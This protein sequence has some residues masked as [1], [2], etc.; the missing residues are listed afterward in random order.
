MDGVRLSP[1]GHEQARALAAR[2][3]HLPIRSIY[4]SPLDRTRETARPLAER[5]N[6]EVQIL[7]AI[8]EIDFGDWTGLTLDALAKLPAWRAWNAFRS[9][10]RAPG[11]ESMLEA[12]ARIVEAM[13]RLHERHRDQCI[14][15]FSHGDIIKAA[16]AYWLGVPLDLFLRIEISP[17]SVSMVSLTDDGPRMLCV[18]NADEIQPP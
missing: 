1:A 16:V 6:L 17:A 3:S 11:G 15:L 14:A 10:T 4:S 12:Q 13:N 9:G 2:L 8:Q 5:L 18:N 7:E